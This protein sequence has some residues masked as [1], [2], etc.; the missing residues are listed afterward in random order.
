MQTVCE[1]HEKLIKMIEEIHVALVGDLEQINREGFIPETHRRLDALEAFRS[2]G[3]K[4]TWMIAGVI[5]TGVAAA[6]L[7]FAF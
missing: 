3:I 5:V 1:E 2:V 4:V 7:K 6:V